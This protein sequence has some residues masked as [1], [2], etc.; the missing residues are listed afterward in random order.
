MGLAYRWIR[1]TPY[2][3]DQGIMKRRLATR[4]TVL[5]LVLSVLLTGGMS[6]ALA[7]TPKSGDSDP[8]ITKIFKAC[9][10][11]LPSKKIECMKSEANDVVGDSIEE[12]SKEPVTNRITCLLDRVKGEATQIAGLIYYLHLL[13]QVS[14]G[15]GEDDS[16]LG[17]PSQVLRILS[18]PLVLLEDKELLARLKREVEAEIGEL[19]GVNA[20]GNCKKDASFLGKLNCLRVEYMPEATAK[21]TMTWLAYAQIVVIYLADRKEVGKQLIKLQGDLSQAA[22]DPAKL[23]DQKFRHRLSGELKEAR[24]RGLANLD[25][26]A[27][28]GKELRSGFDR[29]PEITKGVAAVADGIKGIGDL[30]V[31]GPEWDKTFK[32]LDKGFSLP[33]DWGSIFGP[34]GLMDQTNRDLDRLN[35]DLDQTNKD[36]TR[37]NRELDQ[38]NKDLAQMNR[39]LDQM[40]ASINAGMSEIDRQMAGLRIN[41]AKMK[42]IDAREHPEIFE[43]LFRDLDLSGIDDYLRSGPKGDESPVLQTIMSGIL[44][45]IPIAG[46]IKGIGEGINGKD[47]VTGQELSGPERLIGSIVMLR[48]MKAGKKFITAE[49]LSKAMKAEKATG[50]IDG[51]LRKDAWHKVPESLKGYESVTR[52][53]VGYRW[54][55]G[56]GNGIRID[57]GNPNNPQKYQQVD[58]VVINSGGKVVG[59]NGKQISGSIENDPREAHI[60]LDE[61]VKWKEWNKP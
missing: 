36:L 50:K 40:N 60:P 52:K 19:K 59:R 4:M 14:H 58:H 27:S 32:N 26:W 22:G 37:M 2:H 51:W 7:V 17:N 55:D 61:W 48:W 31:G 54:N 56:K 46:D 21:E 45:F 41:L 33:S 12:C 3:D 5:V 20:N 8:V 49:E 35:K 16:V 15:R 57:K 28:Y 44:D 29:L 39:E 42:A 13:Y 24:K 11:L 43:H 10:G 34:G 30:N 1:A 53:G 25:F 47:M 6:S 23:R 18:D 9:H 38:M